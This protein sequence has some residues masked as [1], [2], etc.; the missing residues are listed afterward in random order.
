MDAGD[1]GNANAN[2]RV[3]PVEGLRRSSR[4]RASRCAPEPR[5]AR[6]A[7]SGAMEVGV[8]V[9]AGVVDGQMEGAAT[10]NI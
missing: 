8:G 6:S 2:P 1:D 5:S 3:P 9:G 4:H 7:R 10:A